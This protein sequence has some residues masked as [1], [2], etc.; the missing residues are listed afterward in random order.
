MEF[1]QHSLYKNDQNPAVARTARTRPNLECNK[2]R[3]EQKK[4][5]KTDQSQSDRDKN[6]Y[7]YRF[8]F[9]FLTFFFSFLNYVC[10]QNEGLRL[11]GRKR[12]IKKKKIITTPKLLRLG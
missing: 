11:E 10:H 1:Q 4:K 8:R 9:G 5:A 6:I 12:K 3:N 7:I 2:K